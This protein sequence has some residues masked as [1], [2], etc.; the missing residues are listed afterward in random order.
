M[1]FP[2]LGK[3]GRL[4]DGRAGF[5]RATADIQAGNAK[6]FKVTRNADAL[7]LIQPVLDKF[8]AVDAHRH[9]EVGAAGK[10]DAQND[11]GDK[12][13][14]VEKVTAVFVGALIGVRA[15]ELVYKVAVRRVDLYA[16]KP[17]NFGDHRALD[18]LFGHGFHLFGGQC[19][20]HF[21]ND[22]AHHGRRGDDLLAMQQ[23]A[24]GLV[25]RVVQLQ[26]D[27]GV[28]SVH[29]FGKAHKAGDVLRVGGAQLVAGANAGLLINAA[30]LG[31]DQPAAALGAVGIIADDLVRRL[32]CG[33]REPGAH[34]GHD[35]P[36]FQLDLADLAFFKKL[37]ILHET[38]PSFR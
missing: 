15:E 18:K 11:F 8:V 22:L 23:A 7:L 20:G 4:D 29:R 2:A 34:C 31:D 32:P 33:R 35:D 26:K 12:T 5:I 24:H 17:G 30:D 25:A 19:A 10:T 9:R 13:H 21:A 6:A 1:L 16:V 36:V 14:A 38:S 37:W 3:A 27:S 28:V